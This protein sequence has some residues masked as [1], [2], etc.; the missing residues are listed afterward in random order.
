M[1][2]TQPQ[3]HGSATVIV[4]T[5][6][7]LRPLRIHSME[8]PL[9]MEECSQVHLNN[10]MQHKTT[11]DN[12]NHSSNQAATVAITDKNLKLIKTRSVHNSYKI[13]T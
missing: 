10:Q 9:V 13:A 1:S 3:T 5:V 11:L 8:K 2:F 12:V 6:I 7:W 4:I